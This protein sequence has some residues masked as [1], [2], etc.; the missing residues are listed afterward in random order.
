MPSFLFGYFEKLLNGIQKAYIEEHNLTKKYLVQAREGEERLRKTL[1]EYES[2]LYEVQKEKES[3]NYE[4]E[5]LRREMEKVEK[6]KELEVETLSQKVKQMGEQLNQ[7]KIKNS[8]LK[9]ENQ[10]MEGQ[11][12]RLKV[13]LN[14]KREE[15]SSLA[16][17]VQEGGPGM[18]EYAGN[19]DVPAP[20]SYTR[21]LTGDLVLHYRD[22]KQQ[23]LAIHEF[24]RKRTLDSNQQSIFIQ[25]IQKMQQDKF[26]E[27]QK[28]KDDFKQKK[29]KLKEEYEAQM[30]PRLSLS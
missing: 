24:L 15:C 3:N 12:Q 30:Y 20:S 21:Q 26:A 18:G 10:D 8:R 16:R 27:I 11:I 2:F 1:K 4:C 7:K 22:M 23:A 14:N 6:L 5:S 17:K 29:L 13:E 19:E 25:E 28:V 9:S